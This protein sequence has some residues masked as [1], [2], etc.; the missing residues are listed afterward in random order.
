MGWIQSWTPCCWSRGGTTAGTP[1]PC[2]YHQT[3]HSL[4]PLPA[5]KT[6]SAIH[7]SLA[8]FKIAC[9]IYLVQE[10]PKYSPCGSSE[11]DWNVP[12]PLT[13]KSG[14]GPLSSVHERSWLCETWIFAEAFWIQTSKHILCPA[15]CEMWDVFVE[16]V[17]SLATEGSICSTFVFPV[18]KGLSTLCDYTVVLAGAVLSLTPP[19]T[20][21]S[22]FFISIV[23]GTAATGESWSTGN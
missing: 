9:A 14:T 3:L 7:P 19:A 16:E 2:F 12:H 23:T 21:T 17:V 13:A 22:L 5:L 15:E 1:L 4:W 11:T 6:A 8:R 10:G 18:I 20:T